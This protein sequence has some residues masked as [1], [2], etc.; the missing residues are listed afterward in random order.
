[1]WNNHNGHSV[2]T[3]IAHTDGWPAGGRVARLLN[4]NDVQRKIGGPREEN[5]CRNRDERCRCGRKPGKR[6]ERVHGAAGTDA[7]PST[8][9]D[10]ID[11]DHR[12]AAIETE[13]RGR[14]RTTGETTTLPP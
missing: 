12:E 14:P 1:M 11:A 13:E 2:S 4:L 9:R 3:R 8:D 5:T 6:H 10:E 7:H